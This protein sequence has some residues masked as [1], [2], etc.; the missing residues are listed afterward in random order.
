MPHRI[1]PALLLAAAF[2]PAAEA[3]DAPVRPE[4][5]GG[6]L[7]ELRLGLFAHDPWSP[8]GG[9][10]DL[11]GQILLAKPLTLR[12]DLDFLAPRPL[13]GGAINTNGKT[14]H[15][16][17]GL[18]WGLD[19]TPKLFIEGSLGG[20]LHNGRVSRAP[21]PNQNALGCR[22]HFREA[23]T[24]GYRLTPTWSVMASVEHLSNAGLC[25]ANRGL[26]NFGVMIGYRF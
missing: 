6:V 14:S 18:A 4:P 23:A 19:L 12:P 21:R 11:K 7:S 22:A 24:I 8:E 10:A 16:H 15:I 13:L 1:L 9:S 3:G 17:A 5:L 20:A 2:A 25:R 26:T